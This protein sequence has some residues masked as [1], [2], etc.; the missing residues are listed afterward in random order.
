VINLR[1]ATERRYETSSSPEVWHSFDVDNHTEPFGAGF[2]PLQL[3]D[4]DRLPPGAAVP[5]HQHAHAE[6]LTYVCDGA[7]AWHDR[8][9]HSGVL[10][11]GEFQRTGAGPGPRLVETNASGSDWV[12]LFQLGLRS[13]TT[14]GEPGQEQK[15]FSSAERRGT[16]CLVASPTAIKGSLHLDQDA[17][18]YSGLFDA[19][20]HTVHALAEG[21]VAWL[22]VVRGEVLLGDEPLVVGDGAAITAERAVSFT[23]RANTELILVDLPDERHLIITNGHG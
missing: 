16:L 14:G 8:A 4:E 23:A 9:G 10:T 1:R 20:Q 21:R 15:R 3:L 11:A 18:I 19:G 12:H 22:H 13:T 6:C 5:L 7:L 17:F 2:G